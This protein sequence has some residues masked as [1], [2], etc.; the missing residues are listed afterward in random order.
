MLRFDLP[1]IWSNA[2]RLDALST[3]IIVLSALAG[4]PY[5]L[6]LLI[7]QGL[8]RGFIGHARCP[9]HRLYASLL[10]RAGLGGKKENAGAKMFAN[11]LLF[12]AASVASGLYFAGNGM[13]IVPV[14]VL[15]V[16]SFLEAAFAF[17]VAC[18][19]YAAWYRLRGQA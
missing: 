10:C 19:V 9:S 8:V 14:S 12:V 18:W 1:P 17:C 2:A 4:F 5:L 3:F 7:V 13:W 6:P 11:K 16:F 15:A